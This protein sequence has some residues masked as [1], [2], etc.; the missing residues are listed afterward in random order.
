M[1]CEN[2]YHD[3]VTGMKICVIPARGGSKRIPRKNVKPFYGMPMISWSIAA[4]IESD[5]FDHIIVTTDDTDIA[6][7]ARTAG[8]EVP[9]IRPADLSDDHTATVPVISHAI[10][11][12][13]SLWGTPTAVCCLYATAPFVTSDKLVEAYTFLMK[14]RFGDNLN[15]NL[16]ILKINYNILIFIFFKKF[17]I[18]YFDHFYQNF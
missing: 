4:A 13:T 18:L 8:A 17:K 5:I 15:I 16:N 7:V 10:S 1:Y 2:T 3:V 9:F 12:T 14:I 6:D 11:K